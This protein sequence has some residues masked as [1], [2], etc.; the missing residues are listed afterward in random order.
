MLLLLPPREYHPNVGDAA[1]NLAIVYASLGMDGE[2]EQ[3]LGAAEAAWEAAFGEEEAQSRLGL[4]QARVQ[5]HKAA[6][7]GP[8]AG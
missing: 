3:H 5:S 1:A 8:V 4:A 2:A 6:A 7:Q